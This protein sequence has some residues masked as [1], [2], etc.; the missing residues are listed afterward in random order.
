MRIYNTLTRK[1]EEFKPQ[2]PPRVALYTCG[3]TVYDYPHIGNWFTFLRYDVL[4]RAL[5]SAGYKPDWVM[6]ITDVG[7]LVSDADEGEDKLEKGARREGK[8]AWDIAKIYSD[9]FL[10][11]LDRLN[12]TKPSHLP[13][14][15]AHIKEQIDLVSELQAK[16]YTYIIQDGV[17]YDTSKFAD[18]GKLAHLN[19]DQLKEGAR[20]TI[21]PEKKNPTDFAL[22]KFSP[23]DQKRD[24]EWDSPWGKGFPGWHLECS[25]MS[26]KYLGKTLDIHAGGIDHIPVHHTNEIA[27]SEAATGNKLAN[28]WVHMNHIMVNDQKIAKSAGNG[29]TLE[30]IEEKGYSLEALRLLVLQ[31]HYRTQA[32]FSWENLEAAHSRLKR[33]RAIADLR[34]Q[35]QV[36]KDDAVQGDHYENVILGAL[37]NDLDTPGALSLIE[38]A[39]ETFENLHLCSP[40]IELVLEA[41]DGGLGIKLLGPDI[42]EE[43]KGL[44]EG[45]EKARHSKDFEKSDILRSKL[46][47][48]GIGVRDSAQGPIW[49]RL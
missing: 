42:S 30:D 45:R 40:C 47:Q 39:F 22:W 20:V 13:K 19:L 2:Q 27:Q 38:E 3:P 34:W 10:Q 41:I 33:W 9:Y 29:I 15:T 24:M 31:S 18:Y 25:A 12:I 48:Q 21:N 5:Q 16:G 4:V 14:A 26:L 49:Y 43:Q 8:S 37:Q 46:E 35:E 36:A 7:H 28:Y 6:N 23:K 1:V 17:Y 11:G 44:I 32:E